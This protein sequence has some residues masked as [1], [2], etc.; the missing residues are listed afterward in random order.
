[1]PR[2]NHCLTG[3]RTCFIFTVERKDSFW[4][5]LSSEKFWKCKPFKYEAQTI[6][7]QCNPTS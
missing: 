2:K 6:D 3:C 7:N 5:G 4:N 1:M